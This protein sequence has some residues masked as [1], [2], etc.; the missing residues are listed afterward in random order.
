[1]NTF[2]DERKFEKLKELSLSTLAHM[3]NWKMLNRG[4]SQPIF[5]ASFLF[6]PLIRV[7]FL[8]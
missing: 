7:S 5:M 6:M 2:I 8:G 3:L 4:N 1:M